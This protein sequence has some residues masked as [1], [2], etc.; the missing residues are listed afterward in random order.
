MLKNQH[1][2]KILT[3]ILTFF[4]IL[5]FSQTHRFIYEFKYKKDSLTNK[6]DKEE[7]VLDINNNEVQFYEFRAIKIDSIN[8]LCI[9]NNTDF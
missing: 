4:S 3:L 1:K 7:M 6:V 2:M 5:I 8:P 9:L